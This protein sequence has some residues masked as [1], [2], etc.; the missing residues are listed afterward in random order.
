MQ[1]I[2]TIHPVILAVPLPDQQLIRR[3][4]VEALR[5]NARTALVHSARFSGVQMHMDRLEKAEN[6]APLPNAGIHWSLS[7]KSAYV[8]AVTSHKPIGID[9]EQIKPVHDGVRKRTADAAEWALS[10]DP[11]LHLFF[12]YWTAKEAVLKAVGKGLTGLEQCRVIRIVD[13]QRLVLAYEGDQWTVTH[14]WV[15]QEHLVAVT[16]DD[17]AIEWH[18]LDAQAR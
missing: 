12:R 1:P 10:V 7:H 9:I 8:A 3:P 13:A 5:R 11:D 17:V 16:S 14:H 18:V 6:G 4:K 15:G 2:Y